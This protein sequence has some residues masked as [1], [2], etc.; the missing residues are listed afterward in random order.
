MVVRGHL[1][2]SDH[3]MIEFSILGEVRRRVS[4]TTAMDFRRSDY[5]LFRTLAGR[6]P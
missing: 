1:R 3:D 4:R 6:L 2:L 5:G